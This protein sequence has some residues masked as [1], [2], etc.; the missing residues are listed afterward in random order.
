MYVVMRGKD[1]A[2]VAAALKTIEK[3]NAGQ[4]YAKGR[5]QQLSTI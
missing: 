2:A 4:D 3:A 1:L 5:R